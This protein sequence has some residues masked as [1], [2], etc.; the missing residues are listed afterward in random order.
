VSRRALDR[1]ELERLLGHLEREAAEARAGGTRVPGCGQ[2]LLE[3][4]IGI[5]LLPSEL[6]ALLRRYV[7]WMP[8]VGLDAGPSAPLFPS[9]TGARMTRQGIWR[10]WRRALKGAG[11][12]ARASVVVA[13]TSGR[14]VI[15][16][17]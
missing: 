15:G 11:L 3:T 1:A 7:T 17:S 13:A 2:A 8:S 9:R 14:Y 16:C 4:A 12:P 5:G 6:A 10:A